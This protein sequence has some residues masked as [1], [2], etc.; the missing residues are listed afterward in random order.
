VFINTAPTLN[1]AFF[2]GKEIISASCKIVG[3]RIV[4]NYKTV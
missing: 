3:I 1:S 2:V 4:S